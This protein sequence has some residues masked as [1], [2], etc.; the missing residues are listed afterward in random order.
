MVILKVLILKEGINAAN[1]NGRKVSA[2]AETATCLPTFWAT[3]LFLR[4]LLS[5]LPNELETAVK[6]TKKSKKGPKN[7]TSV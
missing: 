5:K 2:A 7:Q 6:N 4:Q 1:N 3:D